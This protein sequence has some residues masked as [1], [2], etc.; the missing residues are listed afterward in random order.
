MNADLVELCPFHQ[1]SFV[2]I[3][4]QFTGPQT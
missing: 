1:R 4:G 3:C 2:F